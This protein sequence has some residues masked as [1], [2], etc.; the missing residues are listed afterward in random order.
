MSTKLNDKK[1]EDAFQGIAHL[2]EKI[3][4]KTV[5]SFFG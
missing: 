1:E 4:N 2:G 3:I 5:K